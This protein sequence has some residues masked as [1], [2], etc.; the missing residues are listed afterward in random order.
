VQ[1]ELAIDAA[2]R[3]DGRLRNIGVPQDRTASKKQAAMH[4]SISGAVKRKAT[5]PFGRETSSAIV[6]LFFV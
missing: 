4:K 2:N 3:D 5:K 1:K 6:R